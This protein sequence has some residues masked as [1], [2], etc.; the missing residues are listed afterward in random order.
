MED[1]FPYFW[2][3]LEHHH[4]SLESLELESMLPSVISVE[5]SLTLNF[6]VV[7]SSHFVPHTYMCI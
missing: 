5:C 4:G 1:D 6:S 2:S 7:Q 3:V